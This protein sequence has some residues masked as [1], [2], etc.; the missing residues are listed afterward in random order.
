MKERLDMLLVKQGYAGSREKAKAII[1]SGSVYVNGVL[2]EEDETFDQMI[3]SGIAG[4]ELTLGA[5]E[6]F[7]LGDNRNSSED[8]RSGN[9][10][11]VKKKDI[12]GK[13]WFRIGEDWE[14]TGLIR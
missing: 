12:I 14:T 11:A 2:L 8:S 5:D 7:V 13:A 6:F 9:I 1:M 10:G 3:D 4:N